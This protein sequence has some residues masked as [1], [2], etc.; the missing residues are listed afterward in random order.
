MPFFDTSEH[1]DA[2][3]LH[4]AQHPHT[5]VVACYCAAWCNTCAGYRT[6]FEQLAQAWPDHA[7]IWIDIEEHPELLDDEDI[8]NFPT[9][10]LQDRTQTRFFGVLQPHIQHLEGLLQRSNTL[11]PVESAP[12]LNTLFV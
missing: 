12:R 1:I 4:L 7:F 3:R 9:L 2:V 8:E 6:E 10:L 11:P 5:M